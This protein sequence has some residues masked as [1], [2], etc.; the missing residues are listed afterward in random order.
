MIETNSWVVV[1][2]NLV[3]FFVRCVGLSTGML[4]HKESDAFECAVFE[5]LNDLR[6][7]VG[8]VKEHM[9]SSSRPFPLSIS[10]H[11]LTLMLDASLQSLQSASVSEQ[12]VANDYYT[13]KF[14]ANLIW[15]L[16]N[17]TE[18]LLLQSFEHRSCMIHFFLPIIFKAFVS[19]R[20]FEISVLGQKQILLR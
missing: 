13:E 6:N 10:C 19:Y 2:E 1:E 5:G 14:A 4:Q 3:P 18:R 11:I 15:N 12:I 16:C 17:L 7:V 9:I 8:V 20:F